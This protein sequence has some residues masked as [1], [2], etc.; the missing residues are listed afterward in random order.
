M[1]QNRVNLIVP[2]CLHLRTIVVYLGEFSETAVNI[3]FQFAM[4]MTKRYGLLGKVEGQ[5]CE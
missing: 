4:L 3:D 1:T 5:E 2:F